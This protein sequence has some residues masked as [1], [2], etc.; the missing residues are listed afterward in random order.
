[1]IIK[2]LDLSI[3]RISDERAIELATMKN[4][5]GSFEWHGR[6]I[7]NCIGWLPA[8]NVVM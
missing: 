5:V 6:V 7:D 3:E 8:E 2:K 1:M 4:I